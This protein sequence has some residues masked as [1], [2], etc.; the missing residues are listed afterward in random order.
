MSRFSHTLISFFPHHIRREIRELYL[1]T[2]ILNIGVAMVLLFEP[3]Y[4]YSIGYSLQQILLFFLIVYILYFFLVPLGARFAKRFGYEH[5]IVVSTFIFIAYYFVLYNIATVPILFFIAPVLYAFQKT[6]YWPAY[7]AD[8][9]RHADRREEGREIGAIDMM[10]LAVNVIAPFLAGVI[11]NFFGFATLFVVVSIIFVVSNIPLLSTPEIF[12]PKPF[13]YALAYKNLAKKPKAVVGYLGYGE[14]L[15]L[16]V[17]WPIFLAL[18]LK[19]FLTVGSLVAFSTLITVIVTLII[20]KTS[21]IKNRRRLLRFGSIGYSLVWFARTIAQTSWGVFVVDTLSR[22][23]KE[24]VSVP[25]VALTYDRAKQKSVM[26]TI[27]TFEMSLVVGKMIALA[28]A[29]LLLLVI[30]QALAY[31][32]LFI[33]AGLMTLLYSRV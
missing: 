14:E 9:A 24:M 1:A 21:D 2:L 4:L 22:L 30:P 3:I 18:V 20:G 6:F 8:F 17:V 29:S 13:P 28:A 16:L 27:M 23:S 5:S 31:P 11:V 26:Q 19:N 32:A 15:I 7:H 25:L 12:V 10:V 33:L